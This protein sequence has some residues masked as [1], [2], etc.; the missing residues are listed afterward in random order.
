MWV[1]HFN[2]MSSF[3]EIWSMLIAQSCSWNTE[4]NS[5]PDNTECFLSDKCQMLYVTWKPDLRV[6][7]FIIAK[8]HIE[9]FLPSTIF[10]WFCENVTITNKT[11]KTGAFASNKKSTTKKV[12]CYKA[13]K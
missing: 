11:S 13:E 9:Y 3:D 12:L 1:F 8:Y 2:F 5:E 10:K 6:W 7:L 4:V